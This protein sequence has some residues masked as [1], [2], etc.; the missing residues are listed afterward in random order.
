MLRLYRTILIASS[1][2]SPKVK[3]TSR[4]GIRIGNGWAKDSGIYEFTMV[5]DGTKA[6]QIF[7]HLAHQGGFQLLCLIIRA[8]VNHPMR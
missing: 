7:L 4:K 3:V 1:F 2:E 6:G 8:T 5:V